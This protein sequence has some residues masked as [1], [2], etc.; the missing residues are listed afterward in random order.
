MTILMI[1]LRKETHQEGN[2]SSLRTTTAIQ[3]P[4]SLPRIKVG[5]REQNL[6][7]KICLLSRSWKARLT[8]CNKKGIASGIKSKGIIDLRAT[9]P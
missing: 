5:A 7:L 9:I 4:M 3:R 8:R 1:G 6:S 2:E